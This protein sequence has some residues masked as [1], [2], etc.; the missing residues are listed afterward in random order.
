MSGE[1]DF[2]SRWSSRKSEAREAEAAAPEPEAPPREDPPQEFTPA[3]LETL[4]DAELCE[5]LNLPDPRTLNEGDDFK[6]FLEGRVP[7]RLRRIALRRLWR[8][9]PIFNQL[10]GLDD[11][12]EDF[13]AA[14]EAGGP[15]QTL[16]KV[17]R[18]FLKTDEPEP[19]GTDT[20]ATPDAPPDRF[21]EENEVA[22]EGCGETRDSS[23]LGNATAGG[24]GDAETDNSGATGPATRRN[25]R[26]RIKSRRMA[27]HFV[28]KPNIPE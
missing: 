26:S 10:D 9:N 15:V 19:E 12:N 25:S 16:Y 2:L 3:E 23:D 24:E 6:V 13:R 17:G 11:Y 27:F 28:E 21:I 7:E 1:K 20:A 18:G 22:R 4:S 5:R 8:S 14:A